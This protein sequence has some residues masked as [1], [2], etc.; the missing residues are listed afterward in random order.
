MAKLSRNPEAH[1]HPI[2]KFSHFSV[3]APLT[4]LIASK[5]IADE[6]PTSQIAFTEDELARISAN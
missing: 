1:F 5:I 2:N 6:G 4:R 3:I